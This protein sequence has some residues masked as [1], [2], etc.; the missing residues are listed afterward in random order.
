LTNTTFDLTTAAGLTLATS[1]TLTVI[2]LLIPQTRAR[3]EALGADAQRS[4]RGVIVLALAALFIAGGCVGVVT[5]APACNVQSIGDYV[6]GVVIA[7][8]LSLASTDGVFLAA[9][10]LRDAQ[11]D[12][13]RLR[14][15]GLPVTLNESP[16][17]G[18]LF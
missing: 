1:V 11:R 7:A 4:V 3:F 5:G 14:E 9:R 8:V 12:D 18:K 10:R 13:Q 2:A 15:I 16:A 6:L 17:G